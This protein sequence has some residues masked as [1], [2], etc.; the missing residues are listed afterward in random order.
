M[1]PDT[2]LDPLFSSAEAPP[3]PWSTATNRLRDAMT[4]LLTT[5]GPDARPHQT[6]IAGIWLDDGFHFVTGR[7][8]RKARNLEGG[9]RN[10]IV[11]AADS[12]WEGID[13]VL[14]GE[15]VEVT[16]ADRLGRLVDAYAAKYDDVF[17]FRLVD[18]RLTNPE[19]TDQVVVYEVVARK[20]FGF[21]KG[22][23]FSQTRWR[24]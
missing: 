8:E 9:N 14:E 4:Y 16:D 21:A 20:A 12:A 19:A 1:D 18:G 24:F 23:T 10:V 15:A 13:V 17:G 5:V 22:T 3:T 7:G 6:T 2:T 11:A